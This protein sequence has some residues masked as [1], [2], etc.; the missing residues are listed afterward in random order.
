MHNILFLRCKWFLSCEFLFFKY[1]Q[2]DRQ[3]KYSFKTHVYI[4]KYVYLDPGNNPKNHIQRV[5]RNPAQMN[6]NIELSLEF[7]EIG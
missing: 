1:I 4:A 5:T 3:N 6:T 2:I 7:R